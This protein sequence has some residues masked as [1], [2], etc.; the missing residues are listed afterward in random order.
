MERRNGRMLSRDCD[1]CSKLKECSKRYRRALKGGRV[2]CPDGTVHLID[3]DSMNQSSEVV[4][5]IQGF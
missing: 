4:C 3:S 2:Y 1:G 5:F